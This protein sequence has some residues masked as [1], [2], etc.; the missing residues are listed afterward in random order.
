MK[1]CDS[2]GGRGLARMRLDNWVL[3]GLY[4][5]GDMRNS[6]FNIHRQFIFNNPDKK[7][8]PVYLK[9]VPYGKDTTFVFVNPTKAGDTIKIKIAALD[10]IANLAPYTTKWGHFDPRD[11]FGYGMWKD[12]ILMRLGETYLLRAEARFKQSNTS[13]AADDIN[14]LRLRAKAA[15]VSPGDIDLNFIL[16][17]RARE[18]IGEENR[19]MTLVRT[20]T[21]VERARRLNGT[22]KIANGNIETTNGLED[23]HMLL[24]IPQNEINLNKD[25]VLKQNPGYK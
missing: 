4:G 11:E 17:E 10:T 7:Y 8:S 9:P 18:L 2:L 16:D 22:T 20:G 15:S 24:P 12:F 23:F 1:I 19:R 5:S 25:A 3:H 21:L 6:K 13:G 14:V